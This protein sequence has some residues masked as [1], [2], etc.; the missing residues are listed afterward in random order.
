MRSKTG[1]SLKKFLSFLLTLSMVL[2][3]LP[4]FALAADGSETKSVGPLNISFTLGADEL[5]T[6][7]ETVDVAAG[8]VITANTPIGSS[9]PVDL[10]FTYAGKTIKIAGIHTNGTNYIN[11]FDAAASTPTADIALYTGTAQLYYYAPAAVTGAL[12][13]DSVSANF[14]NITV[15]KSSDSTVLGT[16]A[17]GTVS[18]EVPCADVL[19]TDGNLRAAITYD[20]RPVPVGKMASVTAHVVVYGTDGIAA[21]TSYAVK[22]GATSTQITNVLNSGGRNINGWKDASTPINGAPWRA[23]VP[24]YDSALVRWVY[25]NPHAVGMKNRGYFEFDAEIQNIYAGNTSAAY[26]IDESGGWYS[27]NMGDFGIYVPTCSLTAPASVQAGKNVTLVYQSEVKN[28]EVTFTYNGKSYGPVAVDP[29]TGTASTT[30]PGAE[31]VSTC[32]VAYAVQTTAAGVKSVPADAT[33][34]FVDE[35][36]DVTFKSGS[37]VHATQTVAKDGY[38]SR[39]SD[40]TA[41]AGQKFAGWV[42][43]AG[44]STPF[45][46]NT[47]ISA[48]TTVYARFVSDTTPTFNVNFYVDSTVYETQTVVKDGFLSRPTDPVKPGYMFVD[49]YTDDTYTAKFNFANPVTANTEAHAKFASTGASRDVTFYWDDGT[50]V[51]EVQNVAN[52]GH[53]VRPTNPVKAGYEFVDWYTDNTY[54]SKFNFGTAINDDGVKAYAKFKKVSET[55]TVTY[56]VNGEYYAEKTGIAH[57]GTVPYKPASPKVDGYTFDGWFK[58]WAD[59]GNGVVEATELA[60]EFTFGT[61]GTKVTEDTT[62]YA[63]LTAIG[64]VNVTY[65][66]GDVGGATVKNKPAGASVLKDAEYTI[67]A[68]TPTA[69]GY[70][71]KGWKIGDLTV[72]P[73]YTFTVTATT[74]IT[75]QWEKIPNKVTVTFD[76]GDTSQLITVP[77]NVI[78][79]EGSSFVI[80]NFV[81]ERAGYI[82]KGWKEGTDNYAPG[83]TYTVAVGTTSVTLTAQWDADQV[84]VTAGTVGT[85]AT[86]AGLPT[87]AVTR[88]TEVA[89]T[90]TVADGYDPAALVVKANDV[91]LAYSAVNGNVYH[92]SFVAN[93]DT[94]ITVSDLAKLSY[95]VTMPVGDNFT[96]KF[97]DNATSKTVTHGEGY[98]FVV[99]PDAGYNIKGVYVNGVKQTAKSTDPNTKAETFKITNV[100]GPQTIEVS[101][102]EIPVYTVTYVV[103][104]AQYTTQ[105]V[106]EGA[107]I[108]TLPEDPVID[109]Y[110]FNGWFT[111]QDG[112]GTAV[113]TN[114]VVNGDMTVYAGLTAKT[115]TVTYDGNG[116]DGGTVPGAQTKNHGVALNLST[117]VPTRTGYKFLGWGT[118]DTA[119]VVSYQPGQTYSADENL[120][121]YAVWEQL[122]FTVTLPS[123]TGFTV[124][125]LDSTTVKYGEDFTFEV[126]VD[127]AY[128]KTAPV[129]SMTPTNAGLGTLTNKSGD[130][131]ENTSATWTYTITGVKE[132]KQI[133]ISVTM[134]PTHVVT[135]KTWLTDVDPTAANTTLYMTQKV[136]NGYPAA[137]PAAPVVEG[138]T[139]GGWVWDDDGNSSTPMVT[140]AFTDPV[141]NPVTIVAKML[142][143]VPVVTWTDVTTP[144]D[145]WDITVDA[146]DVTLVGDS[147]PD[148]GTNTVKYGSDM[149][150]TVTIGEG[151]DASKMAV[152]ANGLAQA[153]ISIEEKSDKTVVYTYK[154]VNI[155]ADTAITVSGVERKTVTITYNANA[156]DD[157]SGMPVQQVVKYYLSDT[158]CDKLSALEPVRTGYEFLGWNTDP[159]AATATHAADAIANFK[160]DTTLYAIW[161]AKDVTVKLTFSDIL[162]NTGEWEKDAVLKETFN[163]VATFNQPVIGD[164]TFKKTTIGGEEVTLGTVAINGGKSVTLKDVEAGSFLNKNSYIEKYWV[165]F[166]AN[167]DE[168]YSDATSAKVD[169]RLNSRALSWTF[170]PNNNKLTIYEGNNTTGT[171]VDSMTAGQ[172]YTLVLPDVVELNAPTYKNAG[173]EVKVG[174]QYEVIWQYRETAK[175][176][177]ETAQEHGSEAYLV[178]SEFSGYAFRALVKPLNAPFTKAATYTNNVPTA[179]NLID[180]AYAQYL[181]TQPTA[182]TVRQETETGLEI[183]GADNEDADVVIN[184]VNTVFSGIGAHKAQFEGQTVTLEATVKETTTG[185]PAVTTGYVNFYR[186]V[187]S[188]TDVLLNTTPVEV[189]ANG[190]A[191]FEVTISDYSTASGQTA[192][193]NVDRF[194]AVYLTNATYKTS[195][196]VTKT[197]TV[198]D[199]PVNDDSVWVKSTAIQ[200]P[201]IESVLEGKIGTATAKATTYNDNLTDLLAG[202]KHTF[203]LR[204]TGAGGVTGQTSDWSVVALDGRT[205]ASTDYTIQWLVTTGTNEEK[206]ANNETA[207]TFVVNESKS[208][209]KYRVKLVPTADGD[210]KTGATSNYV[211]INSLQDVTVLVTASDEIDSTPDSDVYQ[212]NDITLTA[213][214]QGKDSQ[215]MLP[216]GNVTFYYSVNG[217]SWVEIGTAALKQDDVSRTMKATFVTD[218]LPVDVDNGYKQE[219]VTITA[220]YAGD[221]TFQKSGEFNTTTKE[222]TDTVAGAVTDETVTVY[223]SVVYVA[224]NENKASGTVTDG[225]NITAN[226]SLVANETNVTLTLSDIYTLDHAINLSK[227]V[228]GTDYTVQWQ[229]LDNAIQNQDKDTSGNVI[230]GSYTTTNKWSDIN[231]EINRSY[232]ISSVVQDAAYRA[233]I[234]VTNTA[235]VQGSAQGVLQDDADDMTTGRKVYYSNVLV[236]G[237]GQATVTTNITTSANTKFNEEGIVEG[238]TVTIHAL[239]AGASNVTPISNLTVT[240]T[241][242]G[243]SDVVFTDELTTV[244]GYNAFTWNTTG[245]TPGYYTLTVKA[246]SNNGYAP[247][248][249]TRTLIVRDKTYTL[250]ATNESKVYN[251]KAQGIDWSLTDI[252]FEN[253]MA[254]NSVVVYYYE[255]LENGARGMQVEPTQAGDYIYELY[256]PASAYWTELTHVTGEFT[257]TPR[258]V[259]VVD[260][261][262]QAKVYD[263]TT[264]INE[265][266]V[267]LNDSAIDA[268]GVT[269]GETG[270]INGDSIYA[271]GVMTINSAEAGTRT[272][273][274]SNVTLGGDDANNYTV[275]ST[276]YTETI[277]VQRSQVKGDIANSTFQYT[278]SNI[279]VP[280][281]DII[282]IDQAGNVITPANYTVTYYYHNGDGVEQVTAMNKLG[283]YTVIA[284]PEQDNY[285]GGASETIYVVSGTGTDA[286]PTTPTSLT[287][288][289]TDTVVLYTGTQVGVT[290]KDSKGNTI[291]D[292]TYNGSATIPTA[293]GRYLVKVTASTGDTAYGIYTI[294]KA[295]PEFVPTTDV[296]EVT[297]NSAPYSGTVDAGFVA[298]KSDSTAKT[299]ITYTGGTIQG[300][301]YE[302]PTE[303]GKYIATVHVGET[304]NYTAHEEQVAFEIKPKALTITA[305]DLARWQ[306]GSYPDM[307]ATFDGLATEGVAPDTSLRDVQIQ[308]EFIFNDLN[309]DGQPE[310]TNSALD[311][312]GKNYPITVRNALARNYTVTYVAGS[313]AVNELD[314]KADLAIHGMIDNG[315][316]PTQNIAYYGD[317]IQLYAYGNYK[318]NSDGTGVHNPSSL[319]EWSLSAGAPATIDQ[320]GLLTIKGVGTFTVTLTRGSG[321]AA[322]STSITITALKQEVKVVVPELNT[323][324]NAT[325]QD[326]TTTKTMSA[327]NA[328]GVQVFNRNSHFVISGNTRTDVGSQ[329]VTGKVAD[330]IQSFQSETYG[331]LFTINDK[332]VT[333]KPSA[334]TTTYG[335]KA[336]GLTYTEVTPAGSDTV[337]TNGKAVSVAD[338]YANLDVSTYEILVAGV[339]NKNYNVKYLTNPDADK[340]TVNPLNLTVSTGTLDANVGM[341]SVSLN[342]VGKYPVDGAEVNASATLGAS[343]VRMYGEP[344]WVMDYALTSLIPGDSLADLALDPLAGNL[345]KFNYNIGANANITYPTRTSTSPTYIGSLTAYPVDTDDSMIAFGNY[346]EIYTEGTQNIYQRP[347]TLKLA[348]GT[349]KLDVLFSDVNSLSEAGRTAYLRDLIV[350]NLNVLKYTEAGQEVGGL[351]TLLKHTANDLDYELTYTYDASGFN[352]TIKAINN[353]WSE[354][355]TIHV[356][357]VKEKYRVVYN[358]FTATSATVTLYHVNLDTGAETAE[359]LPSGNLMCKIFTRTE[360]GSYLGETPVVNVAMQRTSTPGVY[361]VTYPRLVGSYRMFAIAEGGVGYTIV[362]G[363]E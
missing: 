310:Y 13:G 349:N 172:T 272:L 161:K 70:T 347:V 153:P 217:T 11:A 93:A 105:K 104:N 305:D 136:E 138:Y 204:E 52:G 242:K 267:I 2:G 51:Y 297:Y 327:V 314:P 189:G 228:Y 265:L 220:V 12:A 266:E 133:A 193:T 251:G 337:L 195:A 335:T 259:N 118:S 321:T 146:A 48:P 353:Y 331:G 24:T 280:A 154:L 196:S 81:P 236:V 100:T 170:G 68:I 253:A 202:V 295:R 132:D 262:A 169:L 31:V 328:K 264:D 212:L 69:E 54:A 315:L 180:D 288:D 191:T 231:G 130:T 123:G 210:M 213:E 3:M 148:D 243:S 82:F 72:Q 73:G 101:V 339:E 326:Y 323:V 74:T 277:N 140:Y 227:L 115:Y 275:G 302:A 46:F 66:D 230:S 363:I 226:G 330:S 284:R 97:T 348:N 162:G 208:G 316:T 185:T 6:K 308:P 63:K 334:A 109:G 158:D 17:G 346:T 15:K 240:V 14:S 201:V 125:A 287:I 111:E 306:Y 234:T 142:P 324:Y 290:A 194:Y 276:N 7:G 56:L 239:V 128:A 45:N 10:E 219:Q 352:V 141:N 246:T 313:Y 319:L 27:A 184:G 233:E 273:S 356:N 338:A 325:S 35:A 268:N 187:E 44:G 166:K 332:E 144:E 344:N 355:Y 256:L 50:T 42:T 47:K 127:R 342:P 255:K 207:A 269:T 282:L 65:A 112:D 197:S 60:D 362:N 289:I 238:E 224:D 283:K 177:W 57:N 8:V 292:I 257:I 134:N 229:K 304:A 143:I 232:T 18:Y 286:N 317:Q 145:G 155:T 351:A 75:A 301:A 209:D 116:S 87:A 336:S 171:P 203:T 99:T 200:T 329:I 64:K 271:T 278:G 34:N 285:K 61:S 168:G 281:S 250:T 312:V 241:P 173:G 167:V 126:I 86:L 76:D 36:F 71:F 59:N 40:P 96:A 222:I 211:V 53:A 279:T 92:Y 41:P 361:T 25:S 261:V 188:G 291:T 343:N 345:V 55:Y 263:R 58:T 221:E 198:Y 296:A 30:I 131:S 303:V 26:A 223:S 311:Q 29:A 248:N 62:L 322:I 5:L 300:I 157:V 129:V 88:G 85:G 151:W 199:Q 135:F 218:K 163:L 120:K 49:W 83:A 79:D 206:A 28:G 95:T 360:D 225:I 298:D 149:T 244:N 37:A 103:N 235:P 21:N 39:P 78:V 84:T 1:R 307:V 192:L 205:V 98:S 150:F 245:V 182:D 183:L 107:K 23:T 113:T 147:D 252:D 114:T 174:T 299:Y 90:V 102:D 318:S 357:V 117:A 165:E 340:V 16:G 137:Q 91:A 122:T 80:S 350:A 214:V 152:G 22:V 176:G 237:A 249:I 164:V 216:T 260:L 160:T 119:T 110:I 156:R 32:A 43:M 254:L 359:F 274:V 179:G 106:S 9:D 293:A 186:Y 309:G 19:I 77:D 33:L 341:T 190:V 108:T 139:F 124:N 121:L 333:V 4:T 294:V 181:V 20:K 320:D 175:S 354:N 178:T 38:A 247:Q 270:I 159:T 67:P 94:T 215:I 258:P 89:F 358:S